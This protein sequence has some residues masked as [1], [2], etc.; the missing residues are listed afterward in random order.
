[1]GLNQISGWIQPTS[2]PLWHASMDMCGTRIIFCDFS[3]CAGGR[4]PKIHCVSGRNG[5]VLMVKTFYWETQVFNQSKDNSLNTADWRTQLKKIITRQLV[6]QNPFATP[7]TVYV[8]AQWSKRASQVLVNIDSGNGTKLLPK[9]VITLSSMRFPG[10][11][12]HHF[13]MTFRFPLFQHYLSL[14][15]PQYSCCWNGKV[16]SFTIA[17]QIWEIVM[18]FKM[19]TRIKYSYILILYIYI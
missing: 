4:M 8:A 5:G 16:I 1:M 18:Q 11:L 6:S 15:Y 10:P 19:L 7:V 12:L 3:W 9:S 14:P 13:A 2:G 17:F